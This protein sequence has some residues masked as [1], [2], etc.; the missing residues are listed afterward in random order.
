MIVMLVGNKTYREEKGIDMGEFQ[1]EI[2]PGEDVCR[3]SPQTSD[4][5]ST[6]LRGVPEQEC[7]CAQNWY[8]ISLMIGS[9]FIYRP[10]GHE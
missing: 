6:P 7:V 10:L 8:Q 4:T 9:K 2:V 3:G 1:R 5:S